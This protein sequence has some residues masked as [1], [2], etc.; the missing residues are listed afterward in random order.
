MNVRDHF[1]KQY[2]QSNLDEH[3]D[4]FKEIRNEVVYAIC[5]SKINIKK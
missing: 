5:D 4:K 1:W 2:Q 3:H